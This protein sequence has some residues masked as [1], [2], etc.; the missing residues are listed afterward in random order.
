MTISEKD[1][2]KLGELQAA[3]IYV[4]ELLEA[5]IPKEMAKVKQKNTL[6]MRSSA[7]EL[8][9]KTGLSAEESQILDLAVIF[10]NAGYAESLHNPYFHSSKAAKNWM[11][12]E[13]FGEET[14]TRVSQCLNTNL[15]EAEPQNMTEKVYQDVRTGLYADKK[16]VSKTLP[17]VQEE[18]QIQSGN[19]IE[20]AEWLR[21][22]RKDLKDISWNTDEA[23]EMYKKGLKRNIKKIKKLRKKNEGNIAKFE[24]PIDKSKSAQMILKTALRNHIDLTNIADGKSNIMLSINAIIITIALPLL[25]RYISDN[26]YLIIPVGILMITCVLS[27][28]FAAMATRP[29]KM[30]GE[31]D[32]DRVMEKSSSNLFFFGNFFNVALT[33]YQRGMKKVLR[34]TDV[35]ERS[36]INDL[37]YLGKA[38]GTKFNLLRICYLV[39]MVGIALSV[40]SY[41][42][43]MY[44]TKL[45]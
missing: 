41:A 27:I 42:I 14:I 45:N 22:H 38:L 25:T 36:I 16:Y 15:P 31:T 12:G 6:K 28:V 2:I 26:G 10:T 17:K 29:A 3:E 20:T 5:K 32:V 4:R 34:D 19:P 9:E 40:I 30:Q 33:D 21:Q 7:R 11:K 18:E 24:A 1:K 8:A 43:T 13:D 39:F 23:K 44:F 35:L 37:Y